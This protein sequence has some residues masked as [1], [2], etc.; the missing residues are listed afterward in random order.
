MSKKM[1]FSTVAKKGFGILPKLV[2]SR[3]GKLEPKKEYKKLQMEYIRRRK[4]SMAFEKRKIE[5]YKKGRERAIISR[6]RK[7]GALRAKP[8]YQRAARYGY[9]S[10]FSSGF[11]G[12]GILDIGGTSAGRRPYSTR[13]TRPTIKLGGRGR[14]KKIENLSPYELQMYRKKLKERKQAEQELIESEQSES[15]YAE[16]QPRDNTPSVDV[17]NW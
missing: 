8:M 6:Q 13:T 9:V 5:A 10:P 7:L 1:K 14:P 3:K 4:A 12:G 15:G 11:D 16:E 2:K 17:F